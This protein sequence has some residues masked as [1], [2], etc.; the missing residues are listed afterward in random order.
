MRACLATIDEDNQGKP[1]RPVKKTVLYLLLPVS[2]SLA[3]SLGS[4]LPSGGDSNR[5]ATQVAAGVAATETASAPRATPTQVAASTQAAATSTPAARPAS[6]ASA[7]IGRLGSPSGGQFG[8]I[9]FAAAVLDDN[10]PVDVMDSFPQ[11]VTIV[12]ATYEG[13]GLS[14]GDSYRT[15]WLFNG[16]VQTNLGNKYQWSDSSS[17]KQWED[18]FNKDG[19][20]AG[21]WQMNLYLGGTLQ[22]SAKFEVTPVAAGQPG[23]GPIVFAPGI[24]SNSNAVNPLPANDPTLPAG[25]KNVYAFFSGIDVSKG[26]QWTYQWFH[27]GNVFKTSQIWSWDFQPNDGIHFSLLDQDG[28]INPGTYELKLFFGSS[29]AAIGTVYAPQSK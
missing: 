22:Q 8:P 13:Q 25:A 5:I 26:T 12:Y 11:G 16:Q 4:L 10:S 18:L 19:I 6:T 20:P 28:A 1:M 27:N 21:E 23:F 17:P 3:C 2:L 14:A 29:L 15:E 9:H 7:P 24:D